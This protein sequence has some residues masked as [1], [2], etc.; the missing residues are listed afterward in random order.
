MSKT[1]KLVLIFNLIICLISISF[2]NNFNSNV[3]AITSAE[4][5]ILD[6]YNKKKEEINNSLKSINDKQNNLAGDIG[7]TNNTVSQ[8]N[9]K[10]KKLQEEVQAR[11]KDID[12]VQ[13]QIVSVETLI[14]K[15]DEQV[16]YNESQLEI[17]KGE[18][19]ILIS[20][21]QEQDRITPL[22]TILSSK[23]LG[24]FLT[25]LFSLKNTQE[26]AN[27][28][29]A[30]IDQNQEE[31]AR[32]RQM[33]TEI[34]TQLDDAKALL[35]SKQDSLQ[36][37]ITQTNGEQAK[38]EEILK[39]QEEQIK[40]I[41]EQQ[42]QTQAQLSKIGVDYSAEL[43]RVQAQEQAK[44]DSQARTLYN[45]S[46]GNGNISGGGGA[47]GYLGCYFEA[48]GLNVPT[49]YFTKPAS[50]FLTGGFNCG[51]DGLDI[52][53]GIGTELYAVAEGKMVKK[54]S[55]V[56]SNC[57][58]YG[59]NGGYGNAMWIEHTLPSGQIV[60]TVYMHMNTESPIRVGE[61][62][63]KGQVVGYMGTTGNSSGTHL[64]FS[65]IQG[66]VTKGNTACN[67]GGSGKCYNPSR[68]L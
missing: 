28:L 1:I 62:V 55:A 6:S 15:I 19:K 56:S 3:Y 5:I 58:G 39:Q 23:T 64:H 48:N 61:S 57:W 11:Q 14:K 26:Q 25:S 30:K 36:I 22:Q 17:I 32:N 53:N 31:L 45:K 29:T 66:D 12:N 35:R 50:G 65:M 41:Q 54:T 68:Y 38:Y 47:G 2:N 59:C 21:I 16:V 13:I 40:K 10:S 24:E 42:V 27:T 60:T 46:F 67:Y 20:Q 49:G 18:V 4:Q 44:L 9:N 51:H 7:D 37:L 34:K 52:A 33:Q 8:L 43:S 63:E